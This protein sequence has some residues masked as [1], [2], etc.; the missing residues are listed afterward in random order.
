MKGEVIHIAPKLGRVHLFDADTGRT[1]PR[2][3]FPASTFTA[4]T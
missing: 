1:L 2:I 3:S 4:P